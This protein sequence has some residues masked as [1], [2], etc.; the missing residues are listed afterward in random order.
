[1]AISKSILSALDDILEVSSEFDAFIRACESLAPD[2]TVNPL[3]YVASKQLERHLNRCEE[4]E[5]I[6]R[7]RAI[8]LL[9]DFEKAGLR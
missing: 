8:P 3:V 2:L 9:E 5:K 4:L 1:M 6:L 7:H